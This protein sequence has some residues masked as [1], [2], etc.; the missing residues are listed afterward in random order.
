MKTIELKLLTRFIFIE[1]LFLTILPVIAQ[2][3]TV[4]YNG[5]IIGSDI[6]SFGKDI[7]TALIL[8]EVLGVQTYCS[9]Y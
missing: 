7:G 5:S 4:S 1:I 6:Q 2:D 9:G 8:L 3:F